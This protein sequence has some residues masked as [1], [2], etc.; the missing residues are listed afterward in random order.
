MPSSLTLEARDSIAGA[1]LDAERT[2]GVIWIENATGATLRYLR[3]TGRDAV[4][5]VGRMCAL[6]A[7]SARKPMVAANRASRGSG[8]YAADVDLVL[9]R[10]IVASNV[11][12]DGADAAWR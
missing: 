2:A 3:L 11:S 1:F 5:A 12:A 4:E 6:G 8:V 9:T 7:S 10:S